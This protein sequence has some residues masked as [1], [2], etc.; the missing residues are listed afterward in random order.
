M[1]TKELTYYIVVYN[2][3]RTVYGYERDTVILICPLSPPPVSGRTTWRGPP[4]GTVYFLNN[5]KNPSVDR[6]ERL[7]VMLN[8]ASGAYNLHI[9]NLTIGVD[10]GMFICEVNTDPIQQYFVNLKFYGEYINLYK[11]DDCTIS[12]IFVFFRLLL[13]RLS[14]AYFFS[15]VMCYI[16]HSTSIKI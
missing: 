4:S 11:F 1:D 10:D 7:S 3:Y 6:G 16:V 9:T 2:Q 5:N 12:S 15:Q 8:T 14:V 13:F